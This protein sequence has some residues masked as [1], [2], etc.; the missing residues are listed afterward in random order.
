VRRQSAASLSA[1][2]HRFE[3]SVVCHSFITRVCADG[4]PGTAPRVITP[5]Q[6]S[7]FVQIIISINGVLLYVYF[8]LSLSA[9]QFIYVSALMPISHIGGTASMDDA[10]A[11]PGRY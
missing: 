10:S 8:A 4:A 11:Q 7:I 1:E 9:K 5:F 2:C 6:M 3:L